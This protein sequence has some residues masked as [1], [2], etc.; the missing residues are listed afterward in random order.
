MNRLPWPM[1]RGYVRS[2]Y[3][4][5]R[6]TQL[7]PRAES[8]PATQGSTE[9]I[10]PQ[11]SKHTNAEMQQ[12]LPL[13]QSLTRPRCRPRRGRLSSAERVAEIRFWPNPSLKCCSPNIN[14]RRL[15]IRSI[16]QRLSCYT[17]LE[18]NKL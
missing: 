1:S 14:R 11:T 16:N 13:R 3:A 9:Y 5:F 15:D 10:I 17:M 7:I 4:I 18:E 2:D 12:T 6:G 8:V